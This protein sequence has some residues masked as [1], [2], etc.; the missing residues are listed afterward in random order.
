MWW[1][2]H[3]RLAWRVPFLRKM[4][5]PMCRASENNTSRYVSATMHDR[6]ASDCVRMESLVVVVRRWIGSVV[7]L[8][9]RSKRGAYRGNC[10]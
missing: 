4:P 6:S 2:P 9:L 1:T 3:V 10:H 8:S 7:R 5:P